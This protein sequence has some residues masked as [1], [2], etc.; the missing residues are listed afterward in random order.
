MPKCYNN[1]RELRRKNDKKFLKKK[2]DTIKY[3]GFY[4]S[5]YFY[6]FSGK[7]I[8]A[9]CKGKCTYCNVVCSHEQMG[10]FRFN[11]YE[12]EASYLKMVHDSHKSQWQKQ[13]SNRVSRHAKYDETYGKSNIYR[14]HYDIYRQ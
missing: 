5:T 2:F 8:D 10:C 14:K 3:R 1:P 6:G 11:C 4:Y 13:Q 7:I 9:Y 12:N